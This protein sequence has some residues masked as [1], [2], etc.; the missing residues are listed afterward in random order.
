MKLSWLGTSG[1]VELDDSRLPVHIKPFLPFEFDRLVFDDD[2]GEANLTF[3]GRGRAMT[4]NEIARCADFIVDAF[5]GGVA[6]R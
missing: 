3:A 1:F 4:D 2:T 5:D 6:G